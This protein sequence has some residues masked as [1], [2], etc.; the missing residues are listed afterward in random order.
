M[1]KSV[2]VVAAHADDEALGCSGTI[3]KH[4]Y[5]GDNVHVLL[6]TDGV[7]ARSGI[8]DI[9]KRLASS[10][11]AAKLLKLTSLTN[12]DFPDNQMDSVPLLKIVK[13]VEKIIEELKPE[14]IYTHHIS[15]LNIDHQ[16]THKAVVTACRPQPNFCV[17]EIYSFE[18]LSSTEWQ[19]P[20][21]KSFCPN[22]FIDISNHIDLKKQVLE[23]YIEEMRLAPH[24]R[25]LENILRLNALRGNSIGVSY[26][27]AFMAVR[28]SK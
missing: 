8:N 26:A 12:L 11:A 25:N 3:A 4:I 2:L 27:E 17:K 6:M 15:D 18:I 10:Q 21:F 19:T 13:Q 20:G 22:T 1:N 9:K 7:S 16:V 14:I 23:I 5:N 24:S 28:I